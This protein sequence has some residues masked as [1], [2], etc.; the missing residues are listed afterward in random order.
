[1]VSARDG[2]TVADRLIATALRAAGDPWT[3]DPIRKT[4][5]D[6]V[7]GRFLSPSVRVDLRDD[8]IERRRSG[9]ESLTTGLEH[10]A[11]TPDEWRQAMR[12][13]VKK[14]YTVQYAFGR[15]GV[16]QM[17]RADRRAVGRLVRSQDTY[18]KRFA[19]AIE[20]DTLSPAQI[21]NRAQMY[22]ESATQ[23]HEAGLVA[24]YAG[25]ELSQKPGDGQTECK[26]R[27]KCYLEI[28]EDDAAWRVRWHRTA[29]ESCAD[30]L[31]LGATWN[32]LVIAKP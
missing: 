31:R 12:T 18:L 28:S 8:Y 7:T 25:L 9:V 11:Y 2:L 27:C 23:A 10:G 5:R 14:I 4:Y 17:D 30:C 16:K 6:P 3:Y 19:E 21:A 32:P 13:E 1:M 22:L 29:R 26:A 24:A 15:G 20:A